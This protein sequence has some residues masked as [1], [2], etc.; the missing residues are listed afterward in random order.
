MSAILVSML[1][2][3][4]IYVRAKS[5]DINANSVILNRRVSVPQVPKR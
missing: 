3:F 2:T 5:Q 1:M 4:A